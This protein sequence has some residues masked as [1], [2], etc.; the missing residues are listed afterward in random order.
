MVGSSFLRFAGA[1]AFAFDSVFLVNAFSYSE[2]G[3]TITVNGINYYAPAKPVSSLTGFSKI[4]IGSNDDLLPLT[5]ITAQPEASTFSTEFFEQTVKNF[6]DQDDVFNTGF[7]N[8]NSP[9]PSLLP[10]LWTIKYLENNTHCSI[11]GLSPQPGHAMSIVD[12]LRGT[13]LQV[14]K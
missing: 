8:C 13:F 12:V 2:T 5:V 14:P 7:L 6:T 4:E 11:S 10:N 3:Q 1:L 9:S